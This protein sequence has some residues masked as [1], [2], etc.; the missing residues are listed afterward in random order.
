MYIQGPNARIRVDVHDR[1]RKEGQLGD[2]TTTL[3]PIRRETYR[4]GR[5]WHVNGRS[6][7]D[8]YTDPA[9]GP[10]ADVRPLGQDGGGR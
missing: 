1:C 10:R 8:P 4:K 6:Y 5:W 9:V 7:E 3:T 2:P